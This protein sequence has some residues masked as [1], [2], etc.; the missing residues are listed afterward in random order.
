MATL[1]R[2][3]PSGLLHRFVAGGNGSQHVIAD[4]KINAAVSALPRSENEERGHANAANGGETSTD[5]G[6]N[7]A[8]SRGMRGGGPERSGTRHVAKEDA[9]VAAGSRP[10]P[11]GAS[12]GSHFVSKHEMKRVRQPSDGSCLFHALSFHL[13]SGI[14]GW[15]LRKA[16]CKKI[17]KY[18]DMDFD[19]TSLR[20]WI[21][22]DSG[23]TLEEYVAEIEHGA[24]GGE[25]ELSV[26]AKVTGLT[27][28]VYEPLPGGY[29]QT[30]CFEP[31]S[32]TKGVVDVLFLGRRGHYDTLMIRPESTSKEAKGSSK[33]RH[34]EATGHISRV[35]I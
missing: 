32:R 27:V 1:R 13:G 12:R 28:R 9:Y 4:S 17:R 16:I 29:Q 35:S 25:I 31:A 10:L 18:P 11:R 23:L 3:Y 8:M 26:F 14:D 21:K 34:D 5:T 30:C 7:R 24:W 19:G 2:F 33:A 22:L 15:S 20:E 6:H